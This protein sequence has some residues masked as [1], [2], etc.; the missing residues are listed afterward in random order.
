M[1]IVHT[2]K[3]NGP[4][5]WKAS[6]FH[7][8]SSWIRPLS[9]AAINEL[10]TAVTGIKDRG[11]SFP[12]FTKSDFPL[13]IYSSNLANYGSELETGC[14]FILLRGIPVDFY[15]DE[16]DLDILY[17]GIGLHMGEPVRQNPQGDLIGKVMNIGDLTDRQTRVYETNAY[18]PYHSDPSDLVGLLCIRP[19]KS[20]GISSLISSASLYNEMLGMHPEYLS[21]LYRPMLFPH[22]GDKPCFS[23][24]FNYHQG[25]LSCRYM[26]QY[27]EFGHDTMGHSLSPVEIEAF[28][29]LDHIMQKK[30]MRVDMMMQPGDLQLVNNYT[31]LHSRTSFEDHEELKLRRKKLRL[32]LK[33]PHAR[34]LGYEFPGRDGFPEPCKDMVSSGDH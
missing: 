18:L 20:G 31:V 26:R 33:N 14:G 4:T 29:R 21:V 17:Y 22:V 10:K 9:E 24:I 27:L 11:L 16:S 8:D 23:P 32:W 30:E 5:A 1:G 12:H 13:P 15:D 2:Q 6:D 25:V 19:A 7:N 28:D 3:I 34:Q